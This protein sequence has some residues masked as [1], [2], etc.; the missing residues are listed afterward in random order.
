MLDDFRE[1][2]SSSSFLEEEEHT[3]AAPRPRQTRRHFMGLTPGQRLVLALML[4][5]ITCLLS[6][7]CLLATEKIVIPG[8]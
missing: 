7:F 3:E 4:L 6:T 8:L 1:Q 2:A 5:T